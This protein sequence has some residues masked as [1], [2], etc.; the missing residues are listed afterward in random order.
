MEKNNSEVKQVQ[1]EF[2]QQD[3]EYNNNLKSKLLQ[4]QNLNCAGSSEQ[5]EAINRA[6]HIIVNQLITN[7]INN[8]LVD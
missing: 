1:Q 8:T 6:A 2:E 5:K 4:L 3:L 7:G